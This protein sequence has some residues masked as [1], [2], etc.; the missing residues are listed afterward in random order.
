MVNPMSEF[1]AA[2][3]SA[4]PVTGVDGRPH[5]QVCLGVVGDGLLACLWFMPLI[6]VFAINAIVCAPGL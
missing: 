3:S 5:A 1:G 2:K 6:A 4:R